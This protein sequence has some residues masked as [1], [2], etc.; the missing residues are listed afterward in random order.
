[1]RII[2]FAIALVCLFA[3]IALGQPN[4]PPLDPYGESVPDSPAAELAQANQ[5]DPIALYWAAVANKNLGNG[6][7]AVDLATRAAYRNTLS[8]NLPFF[9]AEA[10][11]FLVE[12]EALEEME[13]E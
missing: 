13:A 11:A 2:G 4:S 7:K 8:A 10:L 5:L 6:H 1:M 3:P 9:R 12:L